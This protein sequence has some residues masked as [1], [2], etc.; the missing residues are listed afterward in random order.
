M[1]VPA[2][3]RKENRLEVVM[4]ARALAAYTLK[5]TSNQN[6]FIPDYDEAV[7]SK[8]Q[9]SVLT[10][11]LNLMDANNI[12]VDDNVEKW[13]ERDKLQKDAA[14]ACN[15]LLNLIYLAQTVYHLRASR[16]KYWSE[17]VLSV[18]GLIRK[19]NHSDCTR[20][21]YLLNESKVKDET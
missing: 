2:G 1:S 15:T 3:Q 4:Q 6:V 16:I 7:K 11:F 14:T 8:I 9:D 18:R 12:R 19:W 10:I 20:Y 17:S 13:K 5:I 21:G